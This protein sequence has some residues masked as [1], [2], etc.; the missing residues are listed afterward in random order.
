MK[1]ILLLTILGVLKAA[2]ALWAQNIFS[3]VYYD[4]TQT[5]GYSVTEAY[6]NGFIIAGSNSYAGFLMKIDSTG[7]QLWNRQFGNASDNAF[8]SI[9]TTNDSSYVAAGRLY[10]ST[11]AALNMGLVKI[12]AAGDTLWSRILP[13]TAE[14]YSVS[15]TFDNGFIT[16]G[17]KHNTGTPSSSM[18]VAKM[19]SSG[20]LQWQKTFTLGDNTNACYS[21]KQTADSGYI[22]MG[23]IV[24]YPPYDSYAALIKLSSAGNVSWTKIYNRPGGG[25]YGGADVIVTNDGYLCYLF[26]NGSP[27]LMKTDLSG[28]VSWCKTYGGYTNACNCALPKLHPSSNGGYVF[29]DGS[30]AGFGAGQEVIKVDSAGNLEWND[31]LSMYVVDVVGSRDNG[32]FILGNGPIYGVHPWTT[33]N[34]QIGVV[35]TDSAG[36]GAACFYP[37]FMSVQA[38]T[39]IAHP[40]SAPPVSGGAAV[41]VHPLI[42]NPVIVDYTGCVSFLG[43]ADELTESDISVFPNPFSD[44]LTVTFSAVQTNSTVR[45]IDLPGK[46]VYNSGVLTGTETLIIPRSGLK[47]GLYLLQLQTEKGIQTKKIIIQ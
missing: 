6:D 19:N 21:V 31:V 25:T 22:V 17:Y 34:P 29:T 35:K 5:S 30:A 18:V 26:A 39:M 16:G 41:A 42:T 7:N 38:D 20:T 11:A 37:N 28:N 1:K 24:S 32:Y 8:N 15:Q 36:N 47:A 4:G 23:S 14:A 2:G 40:V 9:I 10:N 46:E 3:K 43:G 13:N 27:A 44:Q 45:I 33:N 12:N